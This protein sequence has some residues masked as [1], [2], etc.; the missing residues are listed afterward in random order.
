VILGICRHGRSRPSNKSLGRP[1]A[2]PPVSPIVTPC[3]KMSLAT[4]LPAVTYSCPLQPGACG[5]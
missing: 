3:C 1:H 4:P 2:V 5:S